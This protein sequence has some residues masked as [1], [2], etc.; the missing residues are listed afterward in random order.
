MTPAM[1]AFDF[2]AVMVKQ[3]SDCAMDKPAVMLARPKRGRGGFLQ[4]PE[5]SSESERRK[6]FR[7]AVVGRWPHFCHESLRTIVQ[8]AAAK[9]LPDGNRCF[10]RDVEIPFQG[11]RMC[12][13]DFSQFMHRRRAPD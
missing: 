7:R 3:E 5:M 10:Q 8:Q 6:S 2:F 4:A 9:T 12:I 11:R 13:Y 1:R